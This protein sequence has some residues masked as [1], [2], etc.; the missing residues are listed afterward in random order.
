MIHAG[1][2]VIYYLDYFFD[3]FNN[4]TLALWYLHDFGNTYNNLGLLIKAKNDRIGHILDF[5]GIK[6]DTIL[7]QARLPENKLQKAKDLVK[8]ALSKTSISKK[9]LDSLIK[10]LCFVAKVVISSDTFL[11]HLFNYQ[12]KAT[13]LYIHFNQEIWADLLWW[14][15][16]L[17]K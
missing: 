14:H 9:E 6:L 8:N 13:S 2:N 1:Y 7:I 15:H 17:L 11:C 4:W 10:F 12:A 16:F 5:F 3:I